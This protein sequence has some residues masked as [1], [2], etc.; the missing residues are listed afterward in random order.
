MAQLVRIARQDG[1]IKDLT[2]PTVK[3]AWLGSLLRVN[4]V[5]IFNCLVFRELIKSLASSLGAKEVM[6]DM[7]EGYEQACAEDT[8]L[9]A[10]ITVFGK[11]KQITY[12]NDR[13]KKTSPRGS[14]TAQ[15]RAE[16]DFF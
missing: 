16:P 1:N 15:N 4:R 9:E 6:S 10:A 14:H 13:T 3:N 12:C 7:I 8:E 11:K 5:L 2:I